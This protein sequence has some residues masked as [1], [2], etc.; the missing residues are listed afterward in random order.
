MTDDRMRGIRRLATATVAAVLLLIAMGGAV[1][2][3]GSGLACPDWPACYGVW[4][5]PADLHIW[6]EHSHRLWAGVVGLA[7]AGLTTWTLVR[8]RDRPALGGL[9]LTAFVLVL[10]QAGLGAAVV[11]LRLR[12]SLVTAHLGMS[13][14]VAGC[15]IAVAVLARPIE[16]S[17]PTRPTSPAGDGLRRV[18]RLAALA[19]L[20]VLAQAMLG[21]QAT[22]RGAAYVFNAVPIWLA[23]DT[24]TGSSSQWL[25]VLHRGGGYLVAMAVVGLAV[26]VTRRRR[27]DPTLPEWAIRWAITAAGLVVVQVG[28]GLLNVLTRASV[29]SAVAHL[30]VASWLWAICVLIAVRA[31]A[32]SRKQARH[33]R[34][35][36][37]PEATVPRVGVRR[38]AATA[39]PKPAPV[40]DSFTAS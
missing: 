35:V 33:D 8:H 9:S 2:A 20:L 39:D 15:L 22:G 7:V 12:A 40:R 38:W 3:T 31:L 28:L 24:W 36:H 26:A 30:A 1:R 16:S 6:L 17:G 18:G 25:H 37:L 5:P 23:N 11:L 32:E 14:V 29:A 19:G 34:P 21:G 13:L 27:V 4:I 10:V